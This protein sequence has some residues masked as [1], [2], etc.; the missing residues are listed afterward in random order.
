V[1]ARPC[2]SSVLAALVA[3]VAAAGTA[4]GATRTGELSG[5]VLSA[6][7]APICMPRVPCLRPAGGVVLTFT[8][9]G[10]VRA[11]ATTAK[12]GSYK[13]ILAPGTYAV[14]VTERA[15]VRRP[16]PAA[17]TIS[18]GQVNRVTFYLD[19]GIRRAR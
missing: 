6:P 17:V 8:R 14:R 7:A 5:F 3:A 15:G 10:I 19:S 2:A 13:L 9:R 12:D 1:V 11:H 4:A 18:A 16:T